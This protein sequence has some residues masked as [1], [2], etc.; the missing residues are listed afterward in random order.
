MLLVVM[1]MW[2]GYGNWVVGRW[3]GIG[4]VCLGIR[5]LR[6][7]LFYNFISKFYMILLYLI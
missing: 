3:V 1:G 5:V 7:K 2:V 6:N 4:W